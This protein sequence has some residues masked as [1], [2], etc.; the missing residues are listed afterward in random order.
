MALPIGGGVAARQNPDLYALPFQIPATPI[1]YFMRTAREGV[2]LPAT[3]MEVL[4]VVRVPTQGSFGTQLQNI[5]NL[6]WQLLPAPWRPASSLKMYYAFH[7]DNPQLRR[8]GNRGAIT[9]SAPVANVDDQ[10]VMGFTN[11][12]LASRYF[13]VKAGETDVRAVGDID[14]IIREDLVERAW[15]HGDLR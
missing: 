14:Y 1:Q 5:V 9:Y 3:N 13:A 8:G 15:L 6:V 10:P 7:P 4:F 2:A 12:T 11:A